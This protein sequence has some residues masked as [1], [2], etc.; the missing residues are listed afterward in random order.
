MKIKIEIEES[1]AEDEVLIRCRA[2]T[3]EISAI[4]KAVSEASGTAQKLVFYRGNTEYYLSLD[5]IYFFETDETGIS[6]HTKTDAYQT[7]YKL[8]ELENIL[9]GFFMRVSKSA[10]LNTNHI[11]S[12]NRNLT[13]S[14]VVSFLDTHK[15]VYVSRYYYRP[16]ISKLEEKRLHQ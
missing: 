13:A 11:Y 4:Q 7:K 15:Q 2:L 9:P 8:Y 16:L 5:D 14:S 3:E 10:I 1:L 12:I 6:A